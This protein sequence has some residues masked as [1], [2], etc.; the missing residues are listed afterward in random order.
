MITMIAYRSNTS[1]ALAAQPLT[2][3]PLATRRLRLGLDADYGPYRDA[4]TCGLGHS[5]ST[6]IP[7]L[8]RF[9][10]SDAIARPSRHH[11]NAL[12]F[13]DFAIKVETGITYL[14]DGPNMEDKEFIADLLLSRH[15]LLMKNKA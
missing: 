3:V 10:S 8:S 5:R 12:A 11:D 7:I 4:F 1:D 14:G 13:H 15:R 9:L 6:G 2:L